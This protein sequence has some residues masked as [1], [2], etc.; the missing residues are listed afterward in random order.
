MIKNTHC[1]SSGRASIAHVPATQHRMVR[2]HAF[3]EADIA[4]FSKVVANT[5]CYPLESMRLLNI[6]STDAA[7]A[8]KQPSTGGTSLICIARTCFAALYKAYHVYLP[9][10]I[11]HN[12]IAF[13]IFFNISHNIDGFGVE[14]TLFIASSLTC[15]ICS[16]YKVPMSFYLKRS[17]TNTSLCVKTM[18]T[19]RIACNAYA[20]T[21]FEDIPELFI[22]FFLNVYLHTHCAEFSPFLKSMIIS[23]I[24]TV[25]LTPIEFLKTRI[26][27]HNLKLTFTPVSFFIR[28]FTSVLNTFIFFFL[29]ELFQAR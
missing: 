28:V 5:V 3:S 21:L 27:I 23:C 26:I 18:L 24:S 14:H 22:K 7:T 12:Y 25:V 13:N 1:V 16:L 9:Y 20:A 19:P 17:I 29:M 8:V 2:R 11:I 10:S 6:S 15:A 4:T